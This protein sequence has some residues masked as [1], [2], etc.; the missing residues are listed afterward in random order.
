ML[1]KHGQ[2]RQRPFATPSQIVAGIRD[3]ANVFHPRQIVP[4]QIQCIYRPIPIVG[5]VNDQ[6]G[7]SQIRTVEPWV[8]PAPQRKIGIFLQVFDQPLAFVIFNLLAVSTPG[9]HLVV[10]LLWKIQRVDHDRGDA[11]HPLVRGSRQPGRPA[12]LG[13]T[14]HH[15]PLDRRTPFLGCQLFHAIHRSD[16]TLHHRKQQRPALV[17]SRQLEQKCIRDQVIFG[18][19]TQERLIRNLMQH[20]NA[21]SAKL[22]HH[23]SHDPVTVIRFIELAT[24]GN[25]QQHMIFMSQLFGLI[26]HHHVLPRHVH[27]RLRCQFNVVDLAQRVIDFL[28]QF[29]TVNRIRDREVVLEW[30]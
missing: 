30:R 3:I 22:R 8:N 11:N 23:Q 2:R 29:P 19:S 26:D 25:E 7:Q 17:A 10:H 6:F 20:G 18:P 4:V 27:P 13:G 1:E 21:S 28:N 24:P 14:R 15:E 5:P 16:R 12:T 9:F